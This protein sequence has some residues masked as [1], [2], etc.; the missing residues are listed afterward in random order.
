MCFKNNNN[1]IL[2]DFQKQVSGLLSILW[3]RCKSCRG[4]PPNK[5]M[6]PKCITTKRNQLAMCQNSEISSCKGAFLRRPTIER[7]KD[8]RAKY[9]NIVKNRWCKKTPLFSQSFLLHTIVNQRHFKA[10][11]I[12]PVFP[13]KKVDASSRAVLNKGRQFLVW[14][15]KLLAHGKRGP[16]AWHIKRLPGANWK[17][18]S[19]ELRSKY[20]GRLATLVNTIIMAVTHACI[21]CATLLFYA[22][23]DHMVMM[24]K[25]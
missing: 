16:P 9:K 18:E 2:N 20:K 10:V 22:L 25:V 13:H 12:K 4:A 8:T 17:A 21:T 19:Q 14:L 15:C 1:M 5:Q 23:Y 11:T 24:V 3:D 7:I 6:T